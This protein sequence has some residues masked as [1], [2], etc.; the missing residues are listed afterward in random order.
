MATQFSDSVVSGNLTVTGNRFHNGYFDIPEKKK[1]VDANNVV[2]GHTLT[3]TETM[4]RS[5]TSAV[6][7]QTR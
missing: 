5:K 3:D 1:I 7:G 6:L 2:V 4:A